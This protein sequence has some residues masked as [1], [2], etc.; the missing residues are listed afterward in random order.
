MDIKIHFDGCCAPSNPG[1]G[2]AGWVIRI[3][4][5]DPIGYCTYIGEHRTNNEAEYAALYGALLHGIKLGINKGAKVRI[6]GDSKLVVNQVNK[7][8]KNRKEHLQKLMGK[9]D[10][11]LEQY[12]DW[13]LEWIS[14]D[15][16]G[17]ADHLSVKALTDE[18]IKVR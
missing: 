11:L 3:A 16:N 1:Y 13:T 10:G 15:Y 6:Y 14:R 9:V 18:G 4:D 5:E 8:W 12:D 17:E 2:G 7:D